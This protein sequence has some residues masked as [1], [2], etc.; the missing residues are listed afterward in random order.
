[1]AVE[2]LRLRGT[3]RGY[4]LS[5]GG[6]VG[7]GVPAGQFAVGD[8]GHLDVNV[9]AVEQGAAR[10]WP[11]ICPGR[12]SSPRRRS[13]WRGVHRRHQHEAGGEFDRAMHPRDRHLAA[14]QRLAQRF[15]NVPAE[16]RQLVEKQNAVMG[17]RYFARP[18]NRSAAD[19]CLRGR[20]MMRRAHRPLVQQRDAIGQQTHAE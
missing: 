15:Q 6:A 8:G 2:T 4:L 20:G 1:M 9:D 14:L 17:Q 16:F 11:G 18:R 10:A 7:A 12:A 3:G 5:H 13:R 19:Q